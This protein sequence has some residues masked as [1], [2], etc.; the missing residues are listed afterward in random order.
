MKIEK[1]QSSLLTTSTNQQEKSMA[2][3]WISPGEFLM[4]SPID[5]PNRH[6]YDDE[7]A[8][9]VTITKGFWISSCHVTH[10]QWFSVMK[11]EE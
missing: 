5:E 6:L 10:Q 3:V 4:G 9:K 1:K 2:L 11:N 8:F 7:L